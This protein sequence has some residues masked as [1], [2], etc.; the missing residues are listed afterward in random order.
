[1]SFRP[2][3]GREKARL[4][5]MN[6]KLY[7]ACIRVLKKTGAFQ[8][9]YRKKGNSIRRVLGHD[10]EEVYEKALLLRKT[11]DEIPSASKRK[12]TLSQLYDEWSS[13]RF[14]DLS[15]TTAESYRYCWN[16]IPSNIKSC[17]IQK[18]KREAISDA[19][20]KIEK[21]S[22]RSHSGAF[23]STLLG[24]A[25]TKGYLLKSPWH[26]GDRRKKKILSPISGDK[27]LEIFSFASESVRGALALAGF[28]GLRRGEIMALKVEDI[29]LYR[30]LLYVKRARVKVYGANGSEKFKGTKTDKPR[31]V[32]IPDVATPFLKN[33]VKDKSLNELIYPN[34]RNDIHKRLKSA[35]RKANYSEITLH[36]LRHIC[37]SNLMMKSGVAVA[38][39]VLGHSDIS[40]TVDIYGHLNAVYL[41]HQVEK[42]NVLD[43]TLNSFKSRAEQFINHPDS[44]VRNF[45]ADALKI[46]QKLSP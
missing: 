9:D 43:K 22:M 21:E 10:L 37:G 34:F 8:F 27:L 31:V 23:L 24:V 4:M 30:N 20:L 2:L 18:L 46:F 26:A 6:K 1:M 29:D 19:L 28:C 5:A 16:A 39:A 17:E 13:E 35:C 33:S 44:E 40:T 45:A 25:V 41:S 42:A 15:P 38:Q 11:L 32:P 7:P 3:T 36:D 14:P 12:L